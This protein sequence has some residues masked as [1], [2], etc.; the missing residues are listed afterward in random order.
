MEL[1][2]TSRSNGSR[3]TGRAAAGSG[4]TGTPRPQTTVTRLRSDRVSF[5][6]Q[7]LHMLEEQNR[8]AEEQ[9]R[10]AMEQAQQNS[11]SG[12]DKLDVLEKSL[13]ELRNCQKIFARVR[14]GDKVPEEDLRY[15]MQKDPAGYRLAMATRKPKEHPEEHDSVLTDEDRKQLAEDPSPIVSE[16]SHL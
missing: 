8:M 10:Q 16:S 3:P 13:R 11:R 6:S 2:A 15:L 14:A 7:V 4:R 12:K 1:N 5:S 9:K